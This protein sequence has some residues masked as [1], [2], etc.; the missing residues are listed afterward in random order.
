VKAD[1]FFGHMWGSQIFEAG[2]RG[3]RIGVSTS[4]W[5]PFLATCRVTFDD[6][7]VLDI[8]RYIDFEMGRIYEKA[9][10]HG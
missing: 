7:R 2:I 10:Q 6:G 5:G 1:F 9:G 4:A 8:Q 3:N